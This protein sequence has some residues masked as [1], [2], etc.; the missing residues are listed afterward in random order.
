MATVTLSSD[1]SDARA[2]ASNFL[3]HVIDSG[4]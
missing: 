1:L 3:V 4:R 2:S